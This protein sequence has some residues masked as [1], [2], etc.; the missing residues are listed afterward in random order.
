MSF[1]LD[2][3]ENNVIEIGKALG[4]RDRRTDSVASW[5]VV[6]SSFSLIRLEP[7]FG[8]IVDPETVS[9]SMEMFG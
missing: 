7:K 9:K 8:K 1:I 3:L 2:G 4:P 5:S 6:V